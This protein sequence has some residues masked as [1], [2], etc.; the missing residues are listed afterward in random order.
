MSLEKKVKE[1]LQRLEERKDKDEGLICKI[2]R[3]KK[4]EQNE[5]L[6]FEELTNFLPADDKVRLG[7]D[8]VYT[9]KSLTECNYIGYAIPVRYYKYS[10]I[11]LLNYMALFKE[12]DGLKIKNPKFTLNPNKIFKFY[13]V[14]SLHNNYVTFLVKE[15][16]IRYYENTYKVQIVPSGEIRNGNS[17]YWKESAVYYL[18][19]P[20]V[21]GK[22][23]TQDQI[24]SELMF[25]IK[26]NLFRGCK[27]F[28]DEELETFVDKRWFS[29][30][31]MDLSVLKTKI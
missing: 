7:E 18:N 13:D 10:N 1:A 16:E 31:E 20:S 19:P 2:L 17:V 15:Y 4:V 6:G 12:K 28:T 25:P 29:F 21:E 26:P 27:G 30:N 3:N 24:Y 9:V 14:G 23:S 5:F 11:S 22:K 8:R